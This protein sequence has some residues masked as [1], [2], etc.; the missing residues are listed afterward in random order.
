MNLA[1]LRIPTGNA[2][3]VEAVS[4]DALTATREAL[5]RLAQEVNTHAITHISLSTCIVEPTADDCWETTV[6]AQLMQ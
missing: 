6:Y 1:A 5:I 2:V 3:C 4:S